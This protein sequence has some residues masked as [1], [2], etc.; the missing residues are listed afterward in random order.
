M[1]AVVV[2]HGNMSSADTTSASAAV[3]AAGLDKSLMDPLLCARVRPPSGLCGVE[4]IRSK[5]QK[6]TESIWVEG[7]VTDRSE[8]SW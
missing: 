7:N 5:R 8:P 6:S 3:P 1:A 4:L 2:I